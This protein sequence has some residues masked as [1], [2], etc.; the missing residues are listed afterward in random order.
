MSYKA[1]ESGEVNPKNLIIVILITLVLFIIGSLFLGRSEDIGTGNEFSPP[2]GPALLNNS[3]NLYKTMET[4]GQYTRLTNN[5][6]FFA[7]NYLDEYKRKEYSDILF[8]V[9]G[10]VKKTANLVSFEGTFEA[11]SKNVAVELELLKYEQI[12]ITVSYNKNVY[13]DDLPA[14]SRKNQ[15]IATL[16]INENDYIID[17]STSSNKFSISLFDTTETTRENALSRIIENTGELKENEYYTI[18]PSW[19]L[20]GIEE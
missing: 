6:A 15:F 9:K 14:N 8:T 7:R 17:Y 11:S 13:F 4:D 2:D 5:L 18:I 3:A 1:N 16:P 12:K 20:G 19:V 10:A